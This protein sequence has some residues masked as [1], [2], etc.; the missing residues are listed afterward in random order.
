[1]KSRGGGTDCLKVVPGAL[2][3]ISLPEEDSSDSLSEPVAKKRDIAEESCQSV[4]MKSHNGD[5]NIANCL[6][7]NIHVIK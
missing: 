4:R 3:V 7:S 1:M 6:P 2:G 5:E